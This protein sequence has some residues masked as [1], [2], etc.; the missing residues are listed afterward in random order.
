M[1]EPQ[2]VV[3]RQGERWDSL[4]QRVFGHPAAYPLLWDAN[5]IETRTL[6][7]APTLPAG[8][9]LRVP[10]DAVPSHLEAEV[11]PWRR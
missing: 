8:V 2:T 10:E 5:P 4:S 1:G 3:T 9:R 7:F 6:R 11:P